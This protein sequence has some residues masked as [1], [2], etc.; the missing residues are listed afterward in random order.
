MEVEGMEFLL[1]AVDRF[2]VREEFADSLDNPDPVPLIYLLEKG[3]A[4]NDMG[5]VN[6]VAEQTEMEDVGAAA[7]TQQGGRSL[8]AES[9]TRS[10]QSAG[11]VNPQAPGWTKRSIPPPTM[12]RCCSVAVGSS[13][14]S[15]PPGPNP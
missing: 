3:S 6:G 5:E 10:A 13:A 8:R 4:A 9:P 2:P 12:E 1:D 15:L 7:A 11:R 14:L